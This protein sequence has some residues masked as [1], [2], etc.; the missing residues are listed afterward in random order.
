M[1]LDK[2]IDAITSIDLPTGS[3]SGGGIILLLLAMRFAK[4]L[5]KIVF[6]LL[7]LGLITGG[8]W[9]FLQHQH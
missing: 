8:I 6:I 2:I 4:G 7:A 1:S 5:F 9:W 3:L